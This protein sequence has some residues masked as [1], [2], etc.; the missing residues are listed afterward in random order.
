MRAIEI[1][2]A[3]AAG[4][5]GLVLCHNL[6]DP[7]EPRRVAL[8]KGHAL[9]PEDSDLLS[10]LG[11][12]PIHVL[13]LDEGDVGEDEA[14]LRLA[15]AVAGEGVE[16]SGSSE[17]EVRL[18]A[19]VRGLFRVEAD[20]LL[21]ID[22]CDGVMIW[23]LQDR[24]PVEPGR[25][26]ASAK[27]APLAMPEAEL[28]R[29]LELAAPG[30]V[31]VEAYRPRQVG[32]L[33]RERLSGRALERFQQSI[34]TKLSWF[35]APDPS[36]LHVGTTPGEAVEGFR[37]LLELGSELILVGGT[38]S[39]DPLDNTLLAI[40][41]LGGRL[42]RSG[43]PAHPGSTYWLALVGGVPVIGMAS[44]GMF[45][46]MTALDLILPRFFSGEQPSAEMIA[47]LGLGGL[48]EREQTFRF[49]PYGEL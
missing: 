15:R 30:T 13:E 34:S 47:S 45:S 39:T 38:G 31:R 8:R 26:V 28:G 21:R 19:T 37:R 16:I 10:R 4:R 48:I 12:E 42:V 3:E 18:T 25:H 46:K 43:V 9:V 23:T 2:G 36:V 33:V 24:V 35:G 41:E 29:V 17:S 44:C 6:N 1:T 40:R 20:P 11:D 5:A 7:D 32:V 49:P 27:I 14:A 22:S